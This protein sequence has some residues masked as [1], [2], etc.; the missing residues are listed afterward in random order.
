MPD[1]AV[2]RRDGE[3]S[4]TEPSENSTP[5]AAVSSA[6]GAE[7]DEPT[8]VVGA[9]PEAEATEPLA[10]AVE[11]PTEVLG[12]S[13]EV[14][15]ESTEVL[16]EPTEV[17]GEPTEVLP[18]PAAAPAGAT[19]KL[20]KPE[21][22][23]AAASPAPSTPDAPAPET[24]DAG[25]VGDAT[26]VGLGDSGGS[27]ESGGDEASDGGV[28]AALVGAEPGERKGVSKIF[29]IVVGVL[30]L[31]VIACGIG[32]VILY[33]SRDKPTTAAAGDCLKGDGIDP[34]SRKTSNVS[35]QTVAC[36]QKTAKY[37]VVG[38]VENQAESA[39]RAD[40]RLCDPFAGTEFIY[41]EGVSGERGTVLC[42]VTNKG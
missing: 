16:G 11:E 32:G 37:K 35:L 33:T 13:T 4:V 3:P 1:K 23:A 27:V 26:V 36:G 41:W 20:A 34:G 42:L 22:P 38:R 25:D 5:A 31:V 39:A 9:D 17:L 10:G 28:A 7:Q 24:P 12:E 21:P 19:V 40:S 2:P 15:G 18:A 6:A 8:E 14:L 29:A 30:V